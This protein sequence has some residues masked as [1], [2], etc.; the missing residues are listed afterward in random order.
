MNKINTT[1][2]QCE[3]TRRKI[4]IGKIASNDTIDKYILNI[5]DQKIFTH[6]YYKV[7]LALKKERHFKINL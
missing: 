4:Q 7:Y 1:I 2:S 5:R 6:V 3:F